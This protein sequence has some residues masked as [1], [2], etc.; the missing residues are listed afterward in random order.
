V[1]I[2]VDIGNQQRAVVFISDQALKL[3]IHQ[4]LSPRREVKREWVS[5]PHCST[6]RSCGLSTGDNNCLP[7]HQKGWESR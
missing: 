7:H 3:E 5:N 1:Y 4:N 2:A 6:L